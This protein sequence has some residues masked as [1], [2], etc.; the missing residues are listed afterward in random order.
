MQHALPVHGRERFD[1][2]AQ[3]EANSR[4]G[5]RGVSR[6]YSPRGV[7]RTSSITR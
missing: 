3:E 5:L 6:A 7:P 2:L 4:A 1:R